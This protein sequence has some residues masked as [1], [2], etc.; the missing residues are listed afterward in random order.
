MKTNDTTKL[1]MK[2]HGIRK[3]QIFKCN[4]GSCFEKEYYFDEFYRLMR[5]SKYGC[6]FSPDFPD[7]SEIGTIVYRQEM[8]EVTER[9]AN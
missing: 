1:F 8:I 6:Q 3:F 2:I 7:I 5:V 9:F 4:I